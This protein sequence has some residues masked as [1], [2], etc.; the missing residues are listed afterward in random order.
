MVSS[1]GEVAAEDEC[2]RWEEMLSGEAVDL[3]ENTVGLAVT[4]L[5]RCKGNAE[6]GWDKVTIVR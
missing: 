2:Q 3:E 6:Q 5:C 1:V 4:G